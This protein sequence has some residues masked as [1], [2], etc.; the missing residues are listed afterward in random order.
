[1]SSST[2]LM[3]PACTPWCTAAHTGRDGWD[4]DDFAAK[5][6]EV[7]KRCVTPVALVAVGGQTV[8]VAVER[9]ANGNDSGDGL[10]VYP[11]VVAVMGDTEEISPEEALA[12]SR[13]LTAA[14]EIIGRVAS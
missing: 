14:V 8:E 7:S 5:W 2:R 11:P 9:F 3:P 13:A 10:N 12:L 1:M 6:G 4:Q